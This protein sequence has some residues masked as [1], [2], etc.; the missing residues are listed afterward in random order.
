MLHDKSRID[1]ESRLWI[2]LTALITIYPHKPSFPFCFA[3]FIR[4]YR[5][6]QSRHRR[7]KFIIRLIGQKTS[8]IGDSI[9]LL[10]NFGVALLG[11]ATWRRSAEGTES[12]AAAA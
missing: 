11:F 12:F 7:Q 2:I 1:R 3:D 9:T 10:A 8:L 4:I 6:Q 5:R